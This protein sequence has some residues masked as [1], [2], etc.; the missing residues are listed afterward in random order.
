MGMDKRHMFFEPDAFP[1]TQQM[2]MS[3]HRKKV[4]TLSHYHRE[5][6]LASTS[7]HPSPVLK[8]S[9][10]NSLLY[11]SYCTLVSHE[12]QIAALLH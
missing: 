4:K 9:G 6:P 11:R 8:D 7:F 3:K 12:L 5:F 1:V 10:Q 2:T